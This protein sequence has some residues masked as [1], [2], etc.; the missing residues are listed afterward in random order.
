VRRFAPSFVSCSPAAPPGG[1]TLYIRRQG[2]SGLR[3]WFFTDAA[4]RSFVIAGVGLHRST[5][6]VHQVDTDVAGDQ[7]RLGALVLD[8]RRRSRPGRP[9]LSG[10]LDPVRQLHSS[11]LPRRRHALLRPA[12]LRRRVRRPR[13]GSAAAAGRL[14]RQLPLHRQRGELR[15][16]VRH[17][18]AA[19]DESRER[20]HRVR[21][22]TSVLETDDRVPRR[23]RQQVL[24]RLHLRHRAAVLQLRLAEVRET[25]ERGDCDGGGSRHRA[26]ALLLPADVRPERERSDIDQV[27]AVEH[28]VAAAQG[29]GRLSRTGAKE[30]P[31][32]RAPV[33]VC[34][35]LLDSH[36][37]VRRGLEED[38]TA[39][40][41]CDRAEN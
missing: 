34:Q 41:V 3:C 19:I 24:R 31:Q 38:Q 16:F 14:G 23:S 5:G 9:T 21:T 28:Q 27:L 1:L 32:H 4:V 11:H 30:L 12:P 8:S 13:H 40:G 25:V 37:H 39:V 29:A 36:V 22:G 33:G 26:A 17:S 15:A 18:R 35:S 6:N 10:P 20:R 7:P 2:R